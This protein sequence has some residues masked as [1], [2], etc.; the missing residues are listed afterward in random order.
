[1]TNYLSTDQLSAALHLRDLTDP[2][3]GPHAMQLLLAD[4]RTALTD[5]WRI[6]VDTVR[7][8]PIV[9]VADNYDRLGF[10]AGAVTRDQRYSRYI[11]PTTMLRSHTTA[12]IPWLLGQVDPRATYDRLLLLPGLVYRRDAIDRTHVGEPH[13]V[14]LWRIASAQLSVDDL[15][16]M[17]ERLVQAVLPN[18]RWRSVHAVHP[19]TVH[20]RQIDV[21]VDGEWLELAECGLVAPHVLRGA[22]LDPRTWSGLA[23]GMGMDR[24]LML[25]KGIPD[26]RLLRATH[27]RIAEQMADLTPWRPVS[28]LPA[29]SRDLSIVV[30]AQADSQV[31][32][33]QVRTT[34]AS[35]VED[36]ESVEVR[37]RTSYA[38]LPPAARQR[39]GIR[40]EQANV[41]LRVT[42][43]P[44]SST[45]TDKQANGIRD[46]IY[47]ALHQGKVLE[48]IG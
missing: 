34:L 16:A 1:M 28:M 18:A 42:L 36:L 9:A 26:I 39:L 32:G 30:D 38:E 43:R 5:L 35:R 37:A 20:G 45:L 41:L 27:P 8:S 21:L 23:L 3:Q 10:T 2:E 44:L 17:V 14:D 48:L 33:D 7:D 47:L 11:S 31:L 15:E 29:I 46:Q 6:P 22:G 12:A 40:P 24:A 19:Y 4:V 13:Q 25:R